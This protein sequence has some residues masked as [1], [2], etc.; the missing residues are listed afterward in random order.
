ML[1]GPWGD[2]LEIRDDGAGVVAGVVDPAR[3]ADV[4]AK[5]P[6][7]RHRTPVAQ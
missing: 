6:A 1:V 3:L 7:L 2:V 4:R 5:L